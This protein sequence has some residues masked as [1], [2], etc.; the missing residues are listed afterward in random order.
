MFGLTEYLL[1]KMSNDERFMRSALSEARKS[2]GQTSPN[3]AVGAVLVVGNRIVARGHHRQAGFPHAEIE[4]LRGFR[5]KVPKDATVYVTLEPCSTTGRTGACTDQIIR[6]GVKSVVI[7]ATDPNPRHRG[8]GVEILR[9]AG[10]EV[11]AGV[12]AEECNE[13]NESFNKWIATGIPFV[14]AKCGMSLDGRLTRP[15][16]ESRWI[17]SAI[18]RRHAQMLRGQTDAILIGAETL[19]IDNPRLTVRGRREVRQPVRVVMTRSGKLPRNARF[20]TDRFAKN[21]FVYRKMPLG[22]VLAELGQKKVTSVMIEGGGNLLGHALD[23]RLIDK[24]QIYVAPMF[25]GGPIVAFGGHGAIRTHEGAHLERVKFEKIGP[26]I[27]VTGYPK[28]DRAASL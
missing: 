27:C 5:R 4:C 21:S 20:F 12:L 22:V 9:E 26:D 6:A 25:T 8:R 13:L 16:R 14:I 28:Y 1:L 3:P 10:I 24:V 19:R 15:A 11:R 2:I 18:A 23:E 7:G 17:T